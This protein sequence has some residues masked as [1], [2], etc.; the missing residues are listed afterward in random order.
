MSAY[1]TTDE[2]KLLTTAPGDYVT[3]VESAQAGWLGAQ[4]SAHS[5]RINAQL[6]KRY[7]TPFADPVPEQVTLWLAQIVTESLMLRRGVDAQDEQFQ[8]IV[9]MAAR[10]REEIKEAANSQDGLWDLPLNETSVSLITRGGPLGYSEASPYVWST[11][12]AERAT[13]EDESG[14][15]TFYG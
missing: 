10:A 15:G 3:D 4:L 8:S 14:S 12:Q 6:R 9:E 7:S 13:S 1:L 2:F 5:A 11:V